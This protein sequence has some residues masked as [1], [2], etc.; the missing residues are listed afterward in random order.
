MEEQ[1]Q[2]MT[3]EQY[4]NLS[5]VD[6]LA[7]QN[8]S[9]AVRIAELETQINLLNM[10]LQQM[11]QSDDPQEEPSIAGEDPIVEDLGDSPH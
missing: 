7:K 3:R 10:Q 8:A 4:I 1:K 6:S 5:K 11:Q 9:Q 2:E